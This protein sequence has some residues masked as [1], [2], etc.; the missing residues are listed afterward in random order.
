ML[1]KPRVKPLAPAATFHKSL[2]HYEQAN[3]SVNSGHR[4]GDGNSHL[5]SEDGIEE[6]IVAYLLR[7]KR[8]RNRKERENTP[9]K[10]LSGE[11]TLKST[12]WR[13]ELEGLGKGSN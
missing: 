3:R 10:C 2:S 13:E 9:A 1:P 11:E 8:T 4:G 6:K 5:F 12:C 7:D